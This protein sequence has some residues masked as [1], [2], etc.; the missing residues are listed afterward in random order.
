MA[1]NISASHFSEE[2]T[3]PFYPLEKKEIEKDKVPLLTNWLESL[4]ITDV[5]SE[6]E[7]FPEFSSTS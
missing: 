2:K 6:N 1:E 4:G 3:L 5:C 7:G